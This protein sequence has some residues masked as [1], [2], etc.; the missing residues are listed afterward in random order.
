MKI[1]KIIFFVLVAIAATT[2]IT[3]FFTPKSMDMERSIV[4]NASQSTVYQYLSDFKNMNY[5]SPWYN[6]DPETKYNYF[7]EAGV[8]GH[9]YTWKSDNNDVGTG[10]MSF[11]SLNYPNQLNYQLK[12]IEPFES[13]A[14]GVFNLENQ[15]EKTKVSWTFHTDFS[16]LQSVFMLFIDMK[17]MLEKD[18]DKGLSQLQQANLVSNNTEMVEE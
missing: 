16:R 15:G 9:G 11:T 7:G 8:V 4:V 6:I 18:F 13:K 10:N 5:W 2:L 3:S 14:N 12:F 1:V 17:G